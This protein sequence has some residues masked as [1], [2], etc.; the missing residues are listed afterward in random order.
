MKP[1]F[2]TLMIA[3]VMFSM[4]CVK[5]QQPDESRIKI[6][7]TKT[8]GVLK[9]LHAI[10]TEEPLTVQFVTDQGI[11]SSDEI[12]GHFPNGILRR[13]NFGQISNDD[14]RMIIRSPG[15]SVTYR[16]VPSKDKKTFSSYL[17]K[18]EHNYAV[19]VARN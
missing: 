11:V 3:M 8:P 19:L 6:M 2:M 4:I 13:Y 1:K 5:A 7:P 15:L 18:T 17:E 10:P 9:L 16:I 12:K 14:F